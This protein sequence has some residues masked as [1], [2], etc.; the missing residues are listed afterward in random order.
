MIQ[1]SEILAKI[2]RGE[3]V[4]YD[5]VIIEGDLDITGLELPTEHTDRTEDDIRYVL[6]DGSKLISSLIT[7]TK[8]EIRGDVNFG[9]ASFQEQITFRGTKFGGGADFRGTEFLRNVDFGGAEFTGKSAEFWE[10]KFAN[11]A[12]FGGVLFGEGAYFVRAKFGGYAIFLLA[13]FGREA[14]FA[15]TRF[16]GREANFQGAKFCGHTYFDSVEFSGKETNFLRVKFDDNANFEGAKFASGNAN[17]EGAEFAGGNANFVE[18]K[19]TGGDADFE[20]AEFTGGNADFW[21]AEFSGHVNFRG[22]KFTGGGAD[23]GGAEFTGG[24]ADF[25]K[26]EFGGYAVFVGAKFTGGDA[27]FSGAKFVGHVGFE[28]AK[29]TSGDAYFI[30]ATFDKGLCLDFLKYDTLYITWDSIK[31]K[32]NYSGHVYLA[33]IKNFKVIGRFSDADDCYYAYRKASQ[34][35]KI[36]YSQKRFNFSKLL[37]WIGLVSCGYVVRLGTIFLWVLGS[38]L[39]FTLLYNLVPESRGGIAESGLSTVT[40]E[41]V[42]KS[43]LLFTF[44]SDDGAVSPSFWECLYFSFTALTGGTP[45]GLHPVGLCKYAVMIEGVLGY[46]FLA[47]FVVVLARKIIR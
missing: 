36:W 42:N 13:E 28:G 25:W 6:P 9:N 43:T 21:K 31:D 20:G 16:T 17:F 1:A 35:E 45:D 11:N 10:V 47:L 33:L 22:A 23:F 15:E 2:E 34:N 37:D 24:D 46:L 32:L 3:D 44:S 27:D 39:G 12:D 4:E 38:V 41:A 14:F 5:G 18:A 8:T 29:F 19:F 26:A 30:D 40:M 7:I